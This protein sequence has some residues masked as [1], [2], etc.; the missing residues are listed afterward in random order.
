VETIEFVRIAYRKL[1]AHVYFDKTALP[2]RDKLVEFE[3]S[4]EFESKLSAIAELYDSAMQE[5][6]SELLQ[7]ILDSISVLHFPKKMKKSK[8]ETGIN[9]ITVGRPDEHAVISDAQHFIDMSVEGHILGTMWIMK[10]GKRLDDDCYKNARGNR[11]RTALIWDEDNEAIHSPA[12]FE[13]Y[14]AQYTLWRDEGLTC[15]EELLKRKHDVLI[16]TL[17]LKKFYYNTGIVEDKFNSLA[18][19]TDEV[20]SSK[21]KSLHNAILSIMKRYTNKLVEDNVAHS[22][23]VLPIGF[24]PSAVLSNWCLAEFDKGILD[25]WNPSYYGRYVDDIIIVDKIEKDSEIYLMARS[26][27]MLKDAVI[28]FFL[29]KKR[30]YNGSPFVTADN[31]KSTKADKDKPKEETNYKVTAAFCLSNESYLEFQSSKTR[32]IALFAEN[33]SSALLNKFKKEIIENVSEFRLMPEIGEAF[34]KEDFS[35]FY[36]LDNDATVNKLRGVKE[37]SMD[38]YELSKFL[39]K[40]RVVSSLIEDKKTKVFSNVIERMFNG[41]ELL[42]NYTLWERVFEIFV[43]DR[44]Y[45]GF[46]KFYKRIT[47]EIRVLGIELNNIELDAEKIKHSLHLHLTSSLNRVLS[48]LWGDEVKRVKLA[49]QDSSHLLSMREAYF[50]TYMTNRYVMVVP[51]EAMI[52]PND[53]TNANL[54]SFSDCFEYICNGGSSADWSDDYLPY[55][56]HAQDIAIAMLL[57]SICTN[58]IEG[59]ESMHSTYIA[60]ISKNLQDGPT[61][62]SDAFPGHSILSVNTQNASKMRIAI[63]NVNVGNVSNLKEVLKGSKPNR[64]YKRYRGLTELVNC[65]ITELAR[66]APKG[67]AKM[68]VLPENYV[69]FEWL[70]AL[71]SKAAREGIAII[72]GV[73]HLKVDK[74][75]Y[76]YTAV[77]LPFKYFDKIPTTAMFFQLKKQYS[78]EERYIIEGYDCVA[79]EGQAL[80][81]NSMRPLYHWHECYFPVYCCY[82]LAS[83]SDRAEFMSWADMIIAV[84]NNRDTNYFGNIA[85]SLARDLHCYFIQVNTSQYGDSRITQP[86]KSEIRNVI[87]VKGGLND[88][89]L[90]GEV[91]VKSLREFQI[92]SYALQKGGPFK[93]TPPGIDTKIVRRKI[94]R[95][96]GRSSEL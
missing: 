79:V 21:E 63:A 9:V 76:N 93:P 44:N 66:N 43:T 5:G 84:E 39:G 61:E 87:A 60:R 47:E 12:L 6:K 83:I 65:A 57:N 20:C 13:P 15:A 18:E 70:P 62:N 71:A 14:F 95:G 28:D 90:V 37:I 68:L 3:A 23:I 31:D 46:S 53:N 26:E 4:V 2:L 74:C 35:D 52:C 19:D 86:T 33:N 17:D 88:S 91:D 40:Y 81:P 50:K 69:P 67:S 1:K 29:G 56:R 41:R 94:E 89:L 51:P 82:E 8:D 80:N 55:F 30:R 38:K 11:L 22:G 54:S 25:C 59:E 34:S 48:L 32:I 45:N 58:C 64:T 42:E 10:F 7:K 24:L 73:E 72:T 96:N 75:I 85:E 92:Q 27:T 49:M 78:P 77:M 36:R 16:T